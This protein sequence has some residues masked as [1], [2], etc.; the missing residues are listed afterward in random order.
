MANYATFLVEKSKFNSGDFPLFG[1]TYNGSPTMYAEPSDTEPDMML[2]GAQF[3]PI[4]GPSVPFGNLIFDRATGLIGH[5][6]MI[7]GMVVAYAGFAGN[8]LIWQTIGDMLTKG[9]WNL[10]WDELN[11]TDPTG[12]LVKVAKKA[13]GRA[14][15]IKMILNALIAGSQTAPMQNAPDPSKSGGFESPK[16][17]R[18]GSFG[19]LIRELIFLTWKYPLVPTTEGLN[20]PDVDDNI[21]AVNEAMFTFNKGRFGMRDANKAMESVNSPDEI[22]T[23]TLLQMTFG[24][25]R[26]GKDIR[27]ATNPDEPGMNPQLQKKLRGLEMLKVFTEFNERTELES[28]EGGWQALSP[29]D[30]RSTMDKMLTRMAP[31]VAKEISDVTDDA[32]VKSVG[33]TNMLVNKTSHTKRQAS[34]APE[35]VANTSEDRALC[36]R[37]YMNIARRV[38]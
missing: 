1:G 3:A 7:Q 18:F 24:A 9:M 2:I 11:S 32:K 35:F 34:G 20:T 15:I 23:T 12:A 10:S 25:F 16:L 19:E 30:K 37:A 26:K 27:M 38:S 31:A 4:I 8:S 6:Y 14:P 5:P 33:M 13:S 28:I 29:Q 36:L 17:K 21:I 22:N